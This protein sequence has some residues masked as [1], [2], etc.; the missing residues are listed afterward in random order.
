MDGKLFHTNANQGGFKFE[1][2][3]GDLSYKYANDFGAKA[4]LT[5]FSNGFGDRASLS[6]TKNLFTSNDG[7][8]S[9]NTNVGGSKWLNGPFTNQ[10]D[11]NF[12]FNVDHR[13]R[14]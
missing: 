8:T 4:G 5:H 3:G 1:K 13:W 10:R 6:A 12:G 9:I 11:Y 2:S 14:G 7:L